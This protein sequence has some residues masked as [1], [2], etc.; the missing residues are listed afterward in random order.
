VYNAD[1]IYMPTPQEAS[2]L[3][4]HLIRPDQVPSDALE[5]FL[6]GESS[7]K[8]LANLLTEIVETHNL[9]TERMPRELQV[10]DPVLASFAAAAAI[11][12]GESSEDFN[13]IGA[14]MQQ[15]RSGIGSIPL[16]R[17]DI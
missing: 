4:T 9:G 16:I 6:I 14:L 3:L 12:G 17:T 8:P 15:Q 1:K 10:W 13:R 11:L 2:R 7:I 5:P